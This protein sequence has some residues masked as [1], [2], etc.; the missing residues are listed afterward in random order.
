MNRPLRRIA[1]ALMLLFALLFANLNYLQAVESQELNGKPGNSRILLS[2]Y[3][4]QRG[5]ILV[6]GRP[7]AASVATKDELKYLRRYSQGPLYAHTTG[8]YSFVYGATG[9][10]R[11][12]GS[13]LA[14]TD[15][16]L[17]VR[18]FIDT[19]SGKDPQGGTVALTLDP[20]AQQAADKGLAALGNGVRGSV[21]AI[22]PTTGRILAFV[23]R[24][25]YDPNPLASHDGEKLR[26]AYERLDKDPDKPLLSRAIA[27]TYPP[28]STFKLVTAAAALSSGRFTPDGQ[29]PG[30]ARLALPDTSI[31]LPNYDGKPCERG[32]GDTTTLTNALRRSCNTTF[33]SI[34][35]KLGDDALREQARK[36]GFGTKL[37]IPMDVADSVFPDELNRPQT[38]LSSIG[39]FDVRATPLQMAMVVAGI[40]NRGVVMKP[41]I[42]E[43]ILAQDLTQ[44]DDTRREEL[45]TAV[46]PEVAQQLTAMMVDVVENGTGTNARIKDVRVAGKTGTAQ[47]GNG[48]PPHAWFVSFA[49]ADNPQVAVAVVIEDGGGRDEVSG[50]Q[51]AAPIAKAVMEAVL[52]P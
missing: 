10:E 46:A 31:S 9:I 42:V 6:A 35:D 2:E 1:L 41:Y 39:Q 24:P 15:D 33:A 43:Q 12:M 18:R 13:I 16:R 19:I 34:A 36:F 47:Q 32:G 38:A 50:N 49:P 52:R 28:G 21:V 20:R 7:I 44:I 30:P 48:R 8:F 29:V 5:S 22:D 14:G 17:F 3:D 23:S 4:R 37:E 45:S 26:Q 25:S 27:R 40:A 11:A 51:L